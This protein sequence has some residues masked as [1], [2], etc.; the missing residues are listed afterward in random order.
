MI[1][2]A[3][4]ETNPSQSPSF[5]MFYRYTCTKLRW[6]FGRE[7]RHNNWRLTRLTNCSMHELCKSHHH[8]FHCYPQLCRTA[9][10]R[11]RSRTWRWWPWTTSSS[12]GQR[13]TARDAFPPT[14]IPFFANRTWIRK[15]FGCHWIETL[16]FLPA[17][18]PAG[19]WMI[20]GLSSSNKI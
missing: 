17:A 13:A 14:F 3:S 2:S 20:I 5:S 12:R 9:A 11:R 1:A 15:F 6:M 4:F 16:T 8:H 18:K 19:Q 7:C 10:T